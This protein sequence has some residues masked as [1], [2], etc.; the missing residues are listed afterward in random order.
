MVRVDYP[1]V[2]LMADIAQFE[3]ENG[4][5]S[6]DILPKGCEWVA[7]EKEPLPNEHRYF[8]DC[9]RESTAR[10]ADW[11][12][13]ID[14]EADIWFV[15]LTFRNNVSLDVAERERKLWQGQLRDAYLSMTGSRSVRFMVQ[16]ERQQRSTLH[17]HSLIL[18]RG[19]ERL[20]R[21]RWE[22]RWENRACRRKSRAPKGSG[23]HQLRGFARIY[24]ADRAAGYYLAKHT[25]KAYG[26]YVSAE[27]A[28][29]G[30]NIPGW[31]NCCS[32]HRDTGAK[33]AGT[34][35]AAKTVSPQTTAVKAERP[36]RVPSPT[37]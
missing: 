12:M 31:V 34:G 28:W 15:T 27:G 20:S 36:G 30:L 8:Y 21:K 2:R 14:P 29:R 24:P 23:P 35:V 5:H 4:L 19:L 18:G 9:E 37:V 16:L 25:G 11:A 33:L 3:A 7:I 22:F 10:W 32:P 13:G 17:Y 1:E 26:A 6:L